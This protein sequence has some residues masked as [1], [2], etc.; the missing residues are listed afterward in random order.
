MTAAGSRIRRT[1]ATASATPLNHRLGWPSTSTRSGPG[2]VRGGAGAN[3]ALSM[4]GATSRTGR[5]GAQRRHHPGEMRRDR[6]EADGQVEHGGRAEAVGGLVVVVVALVE[7]LGRTTAAARAR[8][9][10]LGRRSTR[11]P[12]RRPQTRRPSQRA[13][14]RARRRAP[15]ARPG[16]ASSPLRSA[17]PQAPAP[18]RRRT[19]P[20]ADHAHP[21]ER[22]SS[23]TRRATRISPRRGC[24]RP[25]RPRRS[26][27]ARRAGAPRR[28]AAAVSRPPRRAARA[29]PGRRARDR[30]RRRPRGSAAGIR[31]FSPSRQKSRLPWAS[32]QTTG[33]ARR[34]RLERRQAEALVPRGL[35]E[36]GRRVEQLVDSAS[37]GATR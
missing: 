25:P 30:A 1:A 31:Q 3:T 29:A 23:A 16:R 36:H 4:P 7:A 17:S 35:D 32:V 14:A 24:A 22:P 20:V 28:I 27:R 2:P 37:L 10:R 34:H 19:R 18:R 8:P 11:S 12:P 33:G 13:A 26:A 21:A 5:V 9:K 15:P 6:D